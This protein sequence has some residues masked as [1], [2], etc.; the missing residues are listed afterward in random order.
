MRAVRRRSLNRQLQGRAICPD[1]E[2]LMGRVRFRQSADIPTSLHQMWVEVR[3]ALT[4][5]TRVSASCM[6]P[7]A[8]WDEPPSDDEHIVK[9]NECMQRAFDNKDD[10]GMHRAC[11]KFRRT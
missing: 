5:G 2:T 7:R 3:L 8:A 9:V 4:D 11:A 1:V 6:R 10:R